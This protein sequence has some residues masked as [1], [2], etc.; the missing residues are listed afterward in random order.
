MVLK[1]INTRRRNPRSNPRR[2]YPR[3]SKPMGRNIKV[4]KK[5]R[6]KSRITGGASMLESV[7]LPFKSFGPWRDVYPGQGTM[8][9]ANDTPGSVLNRARSS[10]NNY[11]SK[12]EGLYKCKSGPNTAKPHKLQRLEIEKK[13]CMEIFQNCEV[14]YYIADTINKLIILCDLVKGNKDTLFRIHSD[15]MKTEPHKSG[16]YGLVNTEE[17]PDVIKEGNIRER[18]QNF[19]DIISRN[20]MQEIFIPLM[21]MKIE[22]KLTS[23]ILK[24]LNVEHID[25]FIERFKEYTGLNDETLL[26]ELYDCNNS[27]LNENPNCMVSILFSLPLSLGVLTTRFAGYPWVIPR[28]RKTKNVEKFNYLVDETNILPPLTDRER[29]LYGNE[30]INIGTGAMYNKIDPNSFFYKFSQKHDQHVLT[31]PS[32]GIDLYYHIFN[33]INNF[34]SRVFTLGCV[35]YLCANHDHSIYEVLLPAVKFGIDYDTTQNPYDWIK[36][37]VER[38]T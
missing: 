29:R 17:L 12:E 27:K 25:I 1:R 2:R 9:Q 8:G 35:A 6:K 36:K 3:K 15:V 34:D 11:I 21:I 33:V 38:S 30:P 31:G 26:G 16:A 23:E 22:G 24:I 28:Q 13:L 19:F 20:I 4:T 10:P 5:R 7:A 32:G 14:N 37:S 18:I